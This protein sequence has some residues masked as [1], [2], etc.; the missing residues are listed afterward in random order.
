MNRDNMIDALVK[1]V[2]GWT[3]KVLVNLVK[4]QRR[5]LLRQLSEDELVK[6][7][8]LL[9]KNEAKGE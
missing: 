3:R 2:D 6:L 4:L 9:R 5:A 1:E 8:V 7:Y